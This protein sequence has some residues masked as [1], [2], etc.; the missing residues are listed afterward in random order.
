M[1]MFRLHAGLD[2]NF[3]ILKRNIPNSALSHFK[4]NSHTLVFKNLNI[5]R[6]TPVRLGP[7]MKPL[8]KEPQFQ[9]AATTG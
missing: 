8:P 3:Q 7:M 9:R 2:M 1:F 5:V 6:V 4:V